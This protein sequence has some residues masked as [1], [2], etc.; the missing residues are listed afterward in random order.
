MVWHMLTPGDPH[1]NLAR[2][3]TSFTAVAQRHAA[4]TNI[5]YEVANEPNGVS[6]PSIKRYA[7]QIIPVIRAQDPEA[8][9]LVG[10]RA[11]SS[12]GV[13]DGADETEVVDNQVNATNIVYTFHFYAASHGSG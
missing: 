5:L 8:V 12:L 10:A 2:A 3:R 13:S 7:E 4:R 6:W 1:V 11:W 9:V